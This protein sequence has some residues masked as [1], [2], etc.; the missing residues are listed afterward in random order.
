MSHSLE[1]ILLFV[2]IKWSFFVGA[3]VLHPQGFEVCFSGNHIKAHLKTFPLHAMKMNKKLREMKMIRNY[4]MK[5]KNKLKTTFV[6]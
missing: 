3:H 6:S 1:K 4:L 5:K 2:P